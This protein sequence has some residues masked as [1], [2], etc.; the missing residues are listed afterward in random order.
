MLA[1]VASVVI[2]LAI[3]AACVSAGVRYAAFRGCAADVAR[4]AEALESMEDT[5]VRADLGAH[6]RYLRER[7]GKGWLYAKRDVF[8]GRLRAETRGLLVAA[9]CEGGAPHLAP[10]HHVVATRSRV[11]GAMLPASVAVPAGWNGKEPLPIVLHLHSGGVDTMMDC[12]PAPQIRGALSVMPLARGSHDYLGVQ[13]TAVEECMDDVRRRYPVSGLYVFG[14]SMGGMGAWLYSQRHAL[15]VAGISPWCG[16]ADPAAWQGVWESP[17][18]EPRSPAGRAWELV[19]ASRAPVAR[20]EQLLTDPRMA[21]FIAHGIADTKIPIG[22]AESM[23][24]ALEGLGPHLRFDVMQGLGHRLPSMY[25]ERIAWLERRS[26]AG[27]RRL[28]PNVPPISAL[29]GAPGRRHARA[30]IPPLSFVSDLSGA[31]RLSLVDPMRR[32]V[33][34]LDVELLREIADMPGPDSQGPTKHDYPGPACAAFENAFAV[35][36]PTDPP[37]H[38]KACA[39]EL[40]TVW[41]TRYGG[42]VRRCT[43]SDG[44]GFFGPRG[45]VDVHPRTLVALG[46]PRSLSEYHLTAML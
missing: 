21:V 24:R 19:R 11:D 6:L 15:D 45:G 41:R 10:G 31:P 30:V 28:A 9:N 7:L 2:G 25:E 36:L 1:A 44:F 3:L 12:F 5:G 4:A 14:T 8:L 43:D 13:M 17:R 32:A 33:H 18:P 16:N 37:E 22:H 20:A 38:L 27:P 29:S 34:T 40:S 46:S 39:D 35:A 26:P 23:A 42:E